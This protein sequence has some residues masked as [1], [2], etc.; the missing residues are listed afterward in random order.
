MPVTT[1][2]TEPKVRHEA[3]FDNNDNIST[4]TIDQY[5]VQA[6]GR[7]NT[8]L[9]QKY[10]I[11]LNALLFTNSS[12]AALLD[13]IEML[14]AAWYLLNVEYEDAT[15]IAMGDDRIDRAESMLKQILTGEL[16]LIDNAGQAFDTK[17]GQEQ[18]ISGNPTNSDCRKFSVNMK[19]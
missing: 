15:G 16:I 9:A 7:V 14:L 8:V 10:T 3:W 4:D 2:T 5:R 17:W 12:A 11:P 6:N 1:Y 19:F 18:V 13:L